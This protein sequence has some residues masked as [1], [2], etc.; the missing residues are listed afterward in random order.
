[1]IRLFHG[2]VRSGKS[3]HM[4]C[5]GVE[6]LLYGNRIV[7]TNLVVKLPE[8]HAY[9][10]KRSPGNRIDL[11]RRIRH[12]SD[13]EA[14]RFWL[15]HAPNEDTPDVSESD[16][17]KGIF[18]DFNPRKEA[19]P[20]G[21]LF[22]IDEAQ[23]LWDSR[24]WMKN[25][26]SLSYYTQQHAKLNDEVIMTCQVLKH[27]EGRIRDLGSEYIE[28]TN[29]SLRRI[30]T[31]FRLPAKLRTETRY[32]CPPSPVDRN[33]V[34]ALNL[35][36]A[37]TY[38]TMAGVGIKG[39][40]LPERKDF[41]GLPVYWLAVPALVLL[42]LM[43][44]IPDKLS[45]ML[46]H[47]TNAKKSEQ[48]SGAKGA[49]VRQDG[50][51]PAVVLA[52]VP[53]GSRSGAERPSGEL[54]SSEVAT[55]TP[56]T[57]SDVEFPK[58]AKP[59]LTGYV[60]ARGMVNFVFSDGMVLTEQDPEIKSAIMTRHTLRLKNGVVYFLR[61]TQPKAISPVLPPAK[62]ALPIEETAL[63]TTSEKADAKEK[64]VANISDSSWEMDKDGVNRLRPGVE[65]KSFTLPK[66][67][68]K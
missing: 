62:T 23:I 39:R 63:A 47:F 57:A 3:Y 21:T 45:D 41:K 20:E 48:G 9:L 42:V 4:W 36:L 33:T 29:Y 12:L 50:S 25:G 6:E 31:F 37:N 26:R 67:S 14:K 46:A 11:H 56:S 13:E 2:Q 64:V 34:A 60:V 1:M 19:H 30:L 17:G 5:D 53:T 16:E 49:P 27:L 44:Y 15:H 59:Q 52:D 51:P 28:C 61:E 40:K 35:E 58:K 24:S 10:E 18:P 43:T 32:K 65:N 7:V 68:L 54:A 55:P 66:F 38:E 8:L 22:L